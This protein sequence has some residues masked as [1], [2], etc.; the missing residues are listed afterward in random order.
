MGKLSFYKSSHKEKY[1]CLLNALSTPLHRTNSRKSYQEAGEKMIRYLEK[2]VG[3][4]DLVGNF[5]LSG[6][7]LNLQ[8]LE[9]P[10]EKILNSLKNSLDKFIQENKL[11][12]SLKID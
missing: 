8:N 4:E 11:N 5:Y 12:I 2:T 9:N 1:F 7:S 6:L 10:S 3:K